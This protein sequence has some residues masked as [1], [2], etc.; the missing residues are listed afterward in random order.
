MASGSQ[1]GI[2]NNPNGRPKG[3]TNE[4]VKKA[5]K[6]ITEFVDKNC[7]LLEEL[8]IEIREEKGAYEAFKC[9]EGI[10]EYS[11]PK[12]SRSEVDVNAKIETVASQL[13]GMDDDTS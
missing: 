11:V 4:D 6:V 1:K 7:E 9:I 2:S 5:R 3:S 10:L 13:A 12:L 8:L